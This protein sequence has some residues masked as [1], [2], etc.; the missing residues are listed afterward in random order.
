[1]EIYDRK[2]CNNIRKFEFGNSSVE[3]SYTELTKDI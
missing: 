3:Y 1:M 2:G